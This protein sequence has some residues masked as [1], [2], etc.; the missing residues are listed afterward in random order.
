MPEEVKR[1]IYTGRYLANLRHIVSLLERMELYD[2]GLELD[3]RF[4]KDP[5]LRAKADD[6]IDRANALAKAY[7]LKD[8]TTDISIPPAV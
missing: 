4:Y 7:I 8:G 6:T 2:E 5:T 1:K 3:F